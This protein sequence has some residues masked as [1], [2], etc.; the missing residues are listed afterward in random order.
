LLAKKTIESPFGLFKLSKMPFTLVISSILIGAFGV[1][2]LFDFFITIFIA[3]PFNALEWDYLSWGLGLGS[4]VI[5]LAGGLSGIFVSLSIFLNQSGWK[6][7]IGY[8]GFSLILGLI[9]GYPIFPL[10]L[11]LGTPFWV[12]LNTVPVALQILVRFLSSEIAAIGLFLLTRSSA[13]LSLDRKR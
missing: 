7:P 6:V 8:F 3:S 1:V 5:C 9:N 10:P 12:F 11:L 2:W 13:K 4:L